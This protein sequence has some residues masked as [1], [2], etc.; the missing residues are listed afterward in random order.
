MEINDVLSFAATAR[1][2]P[3]G[4]SSHPAEAECIGIAAVLKKF[5]QST[6]NRSATGVVSKSD[7]IRNQIQ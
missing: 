1:R 6:C 5:S 7:N 3:T 4:Q 2:V